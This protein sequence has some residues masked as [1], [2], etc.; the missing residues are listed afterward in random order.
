M[1]SHIEDYLF[2]RKSIG[3]LCMKPSLSLLRT[4][5]QSGVTY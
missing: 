3:Y 4:K 5:S 2:Y 1:A